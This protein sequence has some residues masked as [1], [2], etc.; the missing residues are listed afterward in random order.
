MTATGR[1]GTA[2]MPGS[3][4]VSGPYF[5]PESPP[6]SSLLFDDRGHAN[7]YENSWDYRAEI[8]VVSSWTRHKRGPHFDPLAVERE[9]GA[10]GALIT[11]R[12][13]ARMLW[14]LH[15]YPQSKD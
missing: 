2:R 12:M 5:T 8:H 9:L 11:A 15:R 13:P 1:L 14:I 4:T 6:V 10:L 7:R 3:R